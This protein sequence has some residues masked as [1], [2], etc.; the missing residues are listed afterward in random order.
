MKTPT[1]AQLRTRFPGWEIEQKK[2]FPP[3]HPESTRRHSWETL[4]I[5][6]D[7]PPRGQQRSP[8]R[9]ATFRWGSAASH[10]R[11]LLAVLKAWERERR[12]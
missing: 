12:A 4:A 10:R 11:V 3:A 2:L 1:L 9:V 8:L 5:Q 6:N 7:G